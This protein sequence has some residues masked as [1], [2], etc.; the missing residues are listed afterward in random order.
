LTTIQRLTGKQR[1][2][3]LKLTLNEA[4]TSNG[5]G[6]S[7]NQAMDTG[8]KKNANKNPDKHTCQSQ[9]GGAEN[10]LA[11]STIERNMVQPS[12]ENVILSKSKRS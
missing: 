6:Q 7:L 5:E 11:K 12:C 1:K 10:E 4:P 3:K 8:K 9:K 2:A